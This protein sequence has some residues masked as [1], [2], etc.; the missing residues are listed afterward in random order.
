MK[1]RKPDAKSRCAVTGLAYPVHDLIPIELLRQAIVDRVRKDHPKLPNHAMISRQESNRYR[2][3]YVEE[4]LIA[5]RG[6]LSHLE[7]QVARSLVEGDLISA[8]IE[9]DY[10]I[11]RSFAERASDNLAN[12]GGSWIFLLFFALGLGIWI[13][14]NSAGSIRFDPYPFILLNLLLSCVAAVQAPII[15]MSQRR[16]E[17][18]D[19]LRSLNDYRINL[20]AELEI[21]HLH[22]KIDH[23][24]FNQWQRLSEIQELQIE[25][26]QGQSMPR[27]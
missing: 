15:M 26:M 24:L 5:E 19:R 21:R 9:K 14:L 4:M 8:N 17:A 10:A 1:K 12:F 18:K 7:Q 6:E 3:A 25:I 23:L 27:K 20:K 16:Q 22:E 2:A 13:L 11:R